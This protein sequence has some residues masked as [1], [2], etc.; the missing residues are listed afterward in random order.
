MQQQQQH[1]VDINSKMDALATAA[2]EAAKA[3][4][5]IIILNPRMDEFSKDG[6][7]RSNTRS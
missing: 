5:I 2:E 1:N 3:M 7:L 4:L 6:S